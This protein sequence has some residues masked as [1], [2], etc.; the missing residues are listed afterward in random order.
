MDNREEEI[1]RDMFAGG[2][3]SGRGSVSSS[4]GSR[5]FIAIIVGFILLLLGSL[6]ALHAVHA[7]DQKIPLPKLKPFPPFKDRQYFPPK[8]GDSITIGK[9]PLAKDK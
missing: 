4:R 7:A 5:W 1:R 8:A 9:T 3:L 6:F 2:W